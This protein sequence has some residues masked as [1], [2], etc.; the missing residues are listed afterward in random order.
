MRVFSSSEEETLKIGELIGR[1][2]RGA[3]VICLI[4]PLGAGKTTLI[5]GIAKGMGLLE[6]YQVRSP[7]FTLINEYP[8]EK[9]LLIHADLYRV[10]ELDLEEFMGRGVLVVEWGEGLQVCTC[11]IRIEIWQEG[12]VLDFSECEELATALSY[13]KAC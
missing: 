10:K 2:L 5:R 8:T 6:G 1:N 3:E 7:T 11:T 4:G 13:G 9:G 12:R